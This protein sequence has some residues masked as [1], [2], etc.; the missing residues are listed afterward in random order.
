[1]VLGK[2]YQLTITLPARDAL[3]SR[4]TGEPSCPR[5]AGEAVLLLIGRH[6][7]TSWIKFLSLA[8]DSNGYRSNSR[9]LLAAAQHR[10]SWAIADGNKLISADL[11]R[12]S[13]GVKSAH[14]TQTP[15]LRPKC[16]EL[17]RKARWSRQ[18]RR[19][20]NQFDATPPCRLLTL[21]VIAL[22]RHANSV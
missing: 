1:M 3:A 15:L 2:D 4:F 11:S 20:F 8:T 21:K 9:P 10:R 18:L 12:A 16:C 14:M 6:H 19:V 5:A 7:V 22:F 13:S 17:I